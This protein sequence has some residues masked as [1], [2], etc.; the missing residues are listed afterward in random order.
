LNGVL[1]PVSTYTEPTST[2]VVMNTAPVS[3]DEYTFIINSRQVDTATVPASS[4]T[5]TPTGGAATNADAHLKTVD[6]KIQ[7]IVNVKEFGAVGDGVTDDTAAITSWQDEEGVKSGSVGSYACTTAAFKQ[8][9]TK[10]VT[11]SSTD[12]GGFT[13][14]TIN[15]SDVTL[16]N[17]KLTGLNSTQTLNTTTVQSDVT[18]ENCDISGA[19]SFQINTEVSNTR[20]LFNDINVTKYS[21]LLNDNAAAS[22]DHII[23]FNNL[24]SSVA[25]AI[26][27]NNPASGIS[28]VGIIGNICSVVGVPST[29]NSGFSIG[30][31]G[32]DN[33]VVL[34]NMSKG[35]KGE[36]IHV[37]DGQFNTTV[38]A[39]V[40]KEC[41]E[42]GVWVSVGGAG[43][44]TGS[45]VVVAHNQVKAA[46]ASTSGGIY[47]VLDGDGTLSGSPVIGNV[48]TDFDVGLSV[49]NG[50][51]LADGNSVVN[52]D[53]GLDIFSGGLQY[54][55][56]YFSGVDSL[57]RSNGNTIADKVV[58]T[59]KPT[60]L[61]ERV[62]GNAQGAVLKGFTMGTTAVHT[63]GSATL[64]F[65][66]AP[67][68]DRMLGRVIL[69]GSDGTSTLFTTH[70]TKHDGT[71]VTNTDIIKDNTGAVDAAELKITG[72]RLV[73]SFFSVNPVTMTI[74]VD[75]DGTYWLA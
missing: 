65:D 42:E 46:A 58:T 57:V 29:S 3:D 69:M 38:V 11:L 32:S 60:H 17:L 63:G 21:F 9:I 54:G 59:G 26:E 40:L 41:E 74:T 47:M 61:L 31:A 22:E 34:G 64:E 73:F 56:N 62:A 19:G 6:T 27:I 15:E 20:V 66:L 43:G 4:V 13:S 35:A 2:T 24:E 45:P 28:N 68:P 16:S 39:N 49:G 36:A 14:F 72:G 67:A 51:I 25:D 53:T 12:T 37:E 50:L 70:N 8:G 33:N 30:V 5:Y 23:A 44:G 52:A 7:G 18:V 10:D 48:A 71:T 1:A 55:T 75:F